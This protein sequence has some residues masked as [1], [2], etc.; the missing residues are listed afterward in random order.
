MYSASVPTFAAIIA[1]LNDARLREGLPP[2]G[3]LNPLLYGKARS[4]L[5]DIVQ[6]SSSGCQN[7][8][9]TPS[10]GWRAT[11]GWDPVSGL[12]TP[13]FGRLRQLVF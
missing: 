5:N 2:L 1:L 7:Q 11:R 8:G 6:G 13:D 4:G 3:F 9:I 12:G 10:P